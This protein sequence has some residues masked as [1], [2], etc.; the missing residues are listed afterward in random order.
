M[1]TVIKQLLLVPGTPTV[2]DIDGNVNTTVQIGNQ[3][4]M[5]ENLKV[6]I[7]PTATMACSTMPATAVS[8]GRPPSAAVTTRGTG[9]CTVATPV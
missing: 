4:W 3:C 5:R 2:T 8:G 9:T 6:A 7:I 1:Q